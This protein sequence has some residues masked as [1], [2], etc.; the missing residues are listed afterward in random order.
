MRD[1]NLHGTW[2][3]GKAVFLEKEEEMGERGLQG[4]V[5]GSVPPE[6]QLDQNKGRLEMLQSISMMPMLTFFGKLFKEL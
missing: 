2:L 1:K 6:W 4:S 5:P 3:L